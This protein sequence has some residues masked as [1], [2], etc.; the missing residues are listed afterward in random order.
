M[1]SNNF[2]INYSQG[3]EILQELL[4]VLNSDLSR[5]NWRNTRDVEEGEGELADHHQR[6]I[7]ERG[8][9]RKI[10]IESMQLCDTRR[11]AGFSLLEAFMLRDYVL[12]EPAGQ[13]QLHHTGNN[14]RG[15]QKCWWNIRVD[16]GTLAISYGRRLRHPQRL[17]KRNI[18]L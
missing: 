7:A 1:V 12:V 5:I 11:G 13:L 8:N 10:S 14:C 3:F 17:W 2:W 6:I 9:N 4:R 18:C 16:S 15:L